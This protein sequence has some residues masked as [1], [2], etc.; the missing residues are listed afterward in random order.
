MKKI[1]ISGKISGLTEKQYQANFNNAILNI[2]MLHDWEIDSHDIINPLKIK[3]FLG[4]KRWLFYMI[5]DL[6]AQRKCTHSAFQ[7]NWINSRGGVIEYYFAKFIW[8]QE[9]IF[10]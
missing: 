3:P 2:G 4:I 1:Y 10:L 5:N 9:I 8:K 7:R 6:R